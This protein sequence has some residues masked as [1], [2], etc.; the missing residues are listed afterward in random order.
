[1]KIGPG[2]E[3]E[4]RRALV[5][6]VRPGDVGGQQVGRELDAPEAQAEGLGERAGGERFADA[7]EV[8]QQD[9]AAG[10]DA[11]EDEPQ[12]LALA[13]DGL[14]HPVEHLVDEAGALVDR[15]VDGVTVASR[16]GPRSAGHRCSMAATARSI[17]AG[18]DRGG[19]P[20]R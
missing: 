10:E 4:L 1:M 8:L 18:D 20:A 15:S 12:R 19:R 7:G 6:D 13:D 11:G 17:R 16:R 9:V 14:A 5:V 3:H 2:A